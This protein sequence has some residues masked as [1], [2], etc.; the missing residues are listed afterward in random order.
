MGEAYNAL[1]LSH[2]YGL[3]I[4]GLLP[5]PDEEETAQETHHQSASHHR[6]CW[7]WWWW[8]QRRFQN[9]RKDPWI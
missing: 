2:D 3:A 7:W 1:D 9:S 5:N 4:D 6:P 8:Y